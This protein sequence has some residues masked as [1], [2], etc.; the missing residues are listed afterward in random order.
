MNILADASLPGL[1]EAFPDPFK[2]TLYQPHHNLHDML[3]K[4]DILLCRAALKVNRELI[5][6]YPL[7]A[8]ATAS[9]GSD[10]L[11][12]QYL[13]AKNIL[14]L[15]AKGCNALSV[16]DYIL[17][18]LAYLESGHYIGGKKIGII[19][20]GHVGMTVYQRLNTAGFELLCY[21]P[22]KAVDEHDFKSCA[23]EELYACD[24][25]CIHAELH[26]RAIYPSLNLINPQVLTQLKPGC[27]IINAA[28]GGIVDEDALLHHAEQIIYCTDVYLNEP[29]IN[30]KIIEKSLLCTP[31]IAGHSIEAKYAA[32]TV[33]SKKIHHLLGLPTP[34]YLM[35]HQPL[36][37]ENA[38]RDTW[39]EY[40][41]AL[42]NPITET[43]LL[44]QAVQPHAVFSTLRTSHT[45]RHNFNVCLADNIAF[46]IK[47]IF[48]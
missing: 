27:I 19:G 33:V 38:T 7:Y 24:V 3:K 25:L 6:D 2:L 47:Q 14:A 30:K 22:I 16:A 46:K 37:L 31:H 9:S 8:V 13:A 17:S 45:S 21:D 12:H 29:Q 28:R 26:N 20:L 35:P 5:Q 32:V 48:I 1:R 43:R 44:K 10:N 40:A 11:E 15:D 42:Y 23:L 39:Q 41:L 4:Q 36:P 34:V 18:C